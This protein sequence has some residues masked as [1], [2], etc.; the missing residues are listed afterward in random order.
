VFTFIQQPLCN[1][2]TTRFFQNGDITDPPALDEAS[3]IRFAQ[4]IERPASPVFEAPDE[5][6][7]CSTCIKNQH[8]LTQALAAYLPAPSDPKYAE[9]EK[10]YPQHRKGLEERY[11]QVCDRC[12]P[13][14]RE[15]IQATGYAAKTDHLRRMMDKTRSTRYLQYDWQWRHI[16]AYSGAFA[17]WAALLG[18]VLWNTIGAMTRQGGGLKE[19]GRWDLV[20]N[21]LRRSPLDGWE[22]TE[23]LDSVQPLATAALGLGLVSLWWNPCAAAKLHGRPG[24]IVGLNEYWKLQLILNV[25]RLLAWYALRYG[26]ISQFDTSTLNA[27]HAVMLAFNLVVSNFMGYGSRKR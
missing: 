8:L 13:R 20:T 15:R 12:E 7:F 11:P 27:I 16:L 4:A 2:L 22:S 24:R 6:L 21:C 19:E 1:W 3:S 26:R 17:W 14:V 10:A 23:C 25:V 18:Q 5:T 9:Y